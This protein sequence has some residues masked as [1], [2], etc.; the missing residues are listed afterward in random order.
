MDSSIFVNVL[1]AHYGEHFEEFNGALVDSGALVAG[2]SV[3]GAYHGFVSKDFDVYVNL[4]RAT[5]MITGLTRI[6]YNAHLCNVATEYD[7]S[8]LRRNNILT[9][10]EF[11]TADRPVFKS[12]DLMIVA[13]STTVHRVVQ[14]FDLTFCEAWYD[15]VSVD[16][17]DP[18]SL[19]KKSGF[20]RVEY[21][22][23]YLNGNLFTRKRI[24]KYKNRGF[25]IDID[26]TGYDKLVVK[27]APKNTTPNL[28]TMLNYALEGLKGFRGVERDIT[29]NA[30]IVY[31]SANENIEY[32]L[33]RTIGEISCISFRCASL[34]QAIIETHMRVYWLPMLSNRDLITML[35]RYYIRD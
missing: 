26:L 31:L 11:R 28:I 22:E 2:G 20:L 23:G 8:F 29:I 1:R 25:T 6:G 9:R 21:L 18:V 5:T 13:N 32:E 27:H 30:L 34:R 17:T 10:I 19:M 35:N 33:L 15:G 12:V 4:E 16:A 14:N 7:S 3:C 24:R